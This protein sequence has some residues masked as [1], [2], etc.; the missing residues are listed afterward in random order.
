ML[1]KAMEQAKE[2]YSKVNEG[3]YYK[4]GLLYCGKCK[5]K[6]QTRVT[7]FDV[8]FE[9][10]CMCKCE[11]EKY[12]ERLRKERMEEIKK[13]VREY[14]FTD[15][16]MKDFTFDKDDKKNKTVT[17]MAQRY[18]SYFRTNLKDGNGI[19]FYGSV[20]TG[21]TFMA[22][23]IVNALL[24][25]GYSCL[26]TSFARIT[27]TLSGMYEGKQQYLDDLVKYDLLV[28]DDLA[29]ERDTE[30]MNEVVFNI[31]DMRYKTKRPLIIT[32]NLT[33]KDLEEPENVGKQRIY[34]RLLDMCYPVEVDGVDR[35]I[36]GL[37][38]KRN[39]FEKTMEG[40]NG[41]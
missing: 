35:R 25:K 38:D 3:D 12:E 4:D 10:F 19:M 5:C 15:G 29:S 27:N 41:Q 20:G 32:T 30:Y 6:K 21:K 18:V 28:I 16:E 31:I 34:S 14:A 8:T 26:V 1:E 17:E 37:K 40:K 7:L 36:A 33:R 39:N 11:Q 13:K 23:C 9:P 24:N 22:G 2:K